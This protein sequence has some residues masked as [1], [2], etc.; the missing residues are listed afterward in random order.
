MLAILYLLLAVF[1]GDRLR[2]LLLP[3]ARELYAGMTSRG[4]SDVPAWLFDLPAA[5]VMGLPPAIGLTYAAAAILARIPGL[6]GLANPL[7]PANLV[8]MPLLFILSLAMTGRL[9]DRASTLRM[10]ARPGDTPPDDPHERPSGRFLRESAGYLCVMAAFLLF[11]LWLMR[12]SLYV[13]GNQLH[14]GY[15]VFSD[16]APHTALVSSFARGANYPTQYPHFPMDGIRYHFLFYFLC[17]NLDYLGLPIDWAIN[18]P[19]LLGLGSFTTLLGLLGILLTGR[20]AAFLA[21]PALLFFRSSLAV[22]TFVRDRRAAGDTLVGAIRAIGRSTVFLGGTTHEEWGLFNLNVFA[23]QRHF[24]LGLAITVFLLFLFLSLLRTGLRARHPEDGRRPRILRLEGWLFPSWRTCAAALLTIVALPYLHGSALVASLLMLAVAAVFSA[25]R[26]QHLLVAAAGIASALVQARFFSGGAENVAAFRLQFGFLAD[27]PTVWGVLA[28]CIE[29]YGVAFFLMLLLPFVQ[30][31]RFR[32]V[33]SVAFLVPFVFAFAVTL[34]PDVTVNHKYLIL[35]VAL[36]NLLIFDLL[37]R[38]WEKPRL[39]PMARRVDL[40]EGRPEGSGSLIGL[41]AL[42]AR[43]AATGIGRI[44][45]EHTTLLRKV[46]VWVRRT[47]VVVLVLFLTVSGIADAVVF[48]RINRN[49]V[50]M[51]LASP[52]TEW[53]MENTRPDEVF[54]TDTY[55]YDEFF[56]SGRMAYYGHAY[57][58]WSAGH[59]TGA[60]DSLYRQ[61]MD[62]C[63]GDYNTFRALCLQEGISYLL[64]TDSLRN[65]PGSG[66]DDAFF[67]ENFPVL[68]RFPAKSNAVIYDLR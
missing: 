33:T 68:V 30:P 2:R 60:R 50:S 41:P 49:T 19:S 64:A 10:V 28:Y 21:T 59:D 34:T 62:G 7:L 6:I 25:G 12:I 14:A 20:R 15:S 45:L 13:D 35:S 23:N 48:A 22:F 40:E 38:M 24:A 57:Y 27:P 67:A 61:L 65:D 29:L 54:L 8:A 44:A 9:R 3:P 36:S 58:A 63:N 17:G 32:R 11:G 18:L 31:N 39:H 16:F 4:V 53:I 56:Y 1:F 51:D 43:L 5:V 66:Y 52:V 47:A 46:W 42:R 37:A 26:L 55:A